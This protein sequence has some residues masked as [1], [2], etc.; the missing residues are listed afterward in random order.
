MTVAGPPRVAFVLHVMQVAGAEVLVRELI[1]RLGSAIVPHVYCLDAVG[2]IGDALIAE[3][4]P[5]VSFDRRPGLDW[6]LIG[7]MARRVR[8]D[9]IDVLHAHQ[10]T[11]FFYGALAAARVAGRPRVIFTEHGR[12]YPDVVGWKRRLANRWYFDRQADVITAVC[13]F[14][15][16]ALAIKDGFARRRIQ[17]VPNGIDVDRYLPSGEK[18]ELR[19]RL[20]LDPS[21]RYIIIVARFHPVKDHA[22]LIRAFARLVG[23][24]D[25]VD[26]LLVGDGPLRPELEGQIATLG[27]Q[28]RVRLV[29]VRSDVPDWLKAADIFVLCSVSEAASITLLEAMAT[30][31]PSVV[32]AVGG[33]PELVRAGIDG[34]HVPRGDDVALADALAT[35]LADDEQ[36]RLMGQRAAERV[37]QE[38][39]MSTTVERYRALFSAV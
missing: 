17:I 25:D 35:L 37:R 31:L 32:T 4:V 27:I 38:F 23:R 6:P 9:R 29:G 22:T 36:A 1:H 14:S 30:G 11:P 15:A 28:S 10:Y 21:R 33:N 3:G 8:D 26:L 7:R 19:R 12:H 39:Q 20:G 5:V 34:L 18:G 16:D 24:H 2:P 13:E